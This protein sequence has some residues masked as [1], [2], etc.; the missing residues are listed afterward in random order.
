M[1]LNYFKYVSVNFLKTSKIIDAEILP[2]IE[3]KL[4]IL[5]DGCFWNSKMSN[6]LQI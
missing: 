1:E 5:Q 4:Q 2:K 3:L 6:I